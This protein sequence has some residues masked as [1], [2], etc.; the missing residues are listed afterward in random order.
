M[1]KETSEFYGAVLRTPWMN[2]AVKVSLK[3]SRRDVLLL[4]QLIEK[5]LHTE[6]TKTIIP[7]DA[8]DGLNGIAAD[9]LAQ[10]DVPE[11]F[12]QSFRKLTGSG[13]QA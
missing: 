10:A 4:G 3:I 6:D 9:L 11:E 2:E 13:K 12:S 7:A 8:L 5:G 1:N